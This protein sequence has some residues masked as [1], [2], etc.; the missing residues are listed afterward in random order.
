MVGG[1]RRLFS[2]VASTSSYV[3][4]KKNMIYHDTTS[5]HNALKI[6]V[7]TTAAVAHG[8]QTETDLGV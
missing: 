8:T 7:V 1:R 3:F 5:T 6:A 2:C 4:T